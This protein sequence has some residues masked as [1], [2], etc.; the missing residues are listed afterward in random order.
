MQRPVIS[1]FTIRDASTATTT[2]PSTT[3]PS[4]TTTTP[5]TTTTT[6]STTTTSSTTTTNTSTTT[7]TSNT[8][9]T[10]TN[11]PTPTVSDTSKSFNFWEL[12]GISL[13][14]A[15]SGLNFLGYCAGRFLKHYPW[16]INLHFIGSSLTTYWSFAVLIAS[17]VICIIY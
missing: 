8:T 4:T 17:L 15:W 2:T 16:W 14:I 9:S 12:H 13:V 3:T 1:S 6:A 7:P 10:T 11:T 5:S